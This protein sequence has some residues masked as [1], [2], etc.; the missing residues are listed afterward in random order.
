ML[1]R[2]ANVNTQA[3]NRD[4]PW[5]LAGALGRTAMLAAMLE[6][7]A[8][9]VRPISLFATGSAAARSSLLANAAH[10]ETIALLTQSSNID[11]DLVNDLGWTCLLEIVILGDGGLRHAAATRL[12][13]AGGADVNLADREGVSPLAHARR[14]GH[15]EIARLLEDAGAR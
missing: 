6:L 3:S 9:A 10:L 1:A 7:P 2:G 15:V 5:L 8:R 13:L 12:A 11:V 14:R 4:T